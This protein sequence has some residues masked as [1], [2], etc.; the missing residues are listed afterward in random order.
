MAARRRVDP[1]EPLTQSEDAGSKVPEKVL[2]QTIAEEV[3]KAM[4]APSSAPD[5]R[6]PE[7]RIEME[8]IQKAETFQETAMAAPGKDLESKMAGILKEPR[9]KGQT[10]TLIWF[11]P[12]IPGGHLIWRYVFV[13]VAD[14]VLGKAWEMYKKEVP[15]GTGE[16]FIYTIHK[17]MDRELP[18]LHRDVGILKLE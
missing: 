9:V 11:H 3:N 15:K 2:R 14:D 10:Y 18:R 13:D 5:V 4:S 1:A 7:V 6:M 16:G 17:V 12:D 8:P